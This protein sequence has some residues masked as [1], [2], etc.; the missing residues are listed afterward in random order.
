MCM[1][2]SL[3]DR[4]HTIEEFLRRIDIKMDNF[5]R[6]WNVKKRRERRVVKN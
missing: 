6:F 2:R 5:F 4:L 3:D 1:I